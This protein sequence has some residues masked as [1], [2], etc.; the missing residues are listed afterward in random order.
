MVEGKD[1]SLRSIA[2]W[3][4]GSHRFILKKKKNASNTMDLNLG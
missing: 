4:L 1:K 2:S 3:L